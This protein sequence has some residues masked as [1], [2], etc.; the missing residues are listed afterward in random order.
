MKQNLSY[1]ANTFGAFRKPPIHGFGYN[2]HFGGQEWFEA[3]HIGAVWPMWSNDEENDVKKWKTTEIIDPT[4]MPL[5]VGTP[6][7]T[8]RQFVT[9]TETTAGTAGGF[10]V[11]NGR[12][13][14][15]SSSLEPS[16]TVELIMMLNREQVAAN[17][18]KTI[19]AFSNTPP[20]GEE[21]YRI[22]Y[23][24]NT[25]DFAVEV[26]GAEIGGTVKLLDGSVVPD[27]YSPFIVQTTWYRT[28]GGAQ[29]GHFTYINRNLQLF[30]GF[31]AGGTSLDDYRTGDYYICSNSLEK[32]STTAGVTI[33]L[34]TVWTDARDNLVL[35]GGPAIRQQIG[36]FPQLD[37]F[38][39]IQPWVSGERHISPPPPP[40]GHF[41][42]RYPYRSQVH[43]LGR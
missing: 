22:T 41:F 31:T 3:N 2:V 19:F 32:A 42:K 4:K 9:G 37:P 39:P 13:A 7:G 35:D 29:S 36:Y 24:N 43:N 34:A 20:A 14:L 12:D 40:P 18:K 10:K 33:L 15:G 27:A 6:W 11:V 38:W 28:P 16:I 23:N 17:L 1:P 8:G 21:Y 5:L 30:G 25:D 26:V